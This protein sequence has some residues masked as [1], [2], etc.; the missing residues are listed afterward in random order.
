[1]SGRVPNDQSGSTVI[2]QCGLA[3]EKAMMP[4]MIPRPYEATASIASPIL[5]VS[6]M[7]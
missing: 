1:M 5:L 4:R 6:A 3:R 2:I 7:D